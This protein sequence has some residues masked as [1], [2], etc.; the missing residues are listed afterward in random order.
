MDK[1]KLFDSFIEVMSKFAQIRAVVALRDGFI[2]TTPFT[3]CGSVFL[4][5]QT[6]QFLDMEN[7]WH[8]YLVMI[9]QHH[10]ML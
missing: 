10:L 6:Y 5:M 8:P 7:L 4:L 1:Q 3:I 2:M 9:G